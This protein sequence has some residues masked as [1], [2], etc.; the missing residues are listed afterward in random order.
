MIIKSMLFAVVLTLSSL[1]LA[2]GQIEPTVTEAPSPDATTT[3]SVTFSSGTST[4]ATQFC[5]TI[6]G[7]IPQFSVAGGEM[8]DSSDDLEG[9]GVCDVSANVGY[10]DYAA[11]DSGNWGSSILT[12]SGNVVTV[13][14]KTSDGL[15]ELTQKITN[16][17]GNASGP[18]SAK[19]S[20][21]LKNLSSISRTAYILRYADVN[22][23]ND[24]S[25]NDFDFTAQTVYGLEPGN[26]GLSST[27]NTFNIDFGQDTVA[28]GSNHPPDPCNAFTSVATHPFHGDGSFLQFWSVNAA[29]NATKTVIS[30]YKPI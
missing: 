3:C 9:Y 18:G 30:T 24:V 26:R 23:E 19:V 29:H 17:P 7:N 22:A 1:A 11:F 15:W 5:V 8:I 21:A 28:Q 10:Y 25:G 20:M 14:R 6:N 4:N 16:V 13:T 2:Q 27:N 12:H